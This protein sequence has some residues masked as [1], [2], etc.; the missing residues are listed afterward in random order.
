LTVVSK[1]A[2]AMLRS[3]LNWCT[4]QDDLVRSNELD[5][6]RAFIISHEIRRELDSEWESRQWGWWAVVPRQTAHSHTPRR[7]FARHRA[8]QARR[9][10]RHRPNSQTPCQC[11]SGN[12]ARHRTRPARHRRC[13]GLA[14]NRHRCPSPASPRHR[15]TVG[16]QQQRFEIALPPISVTVTPEEPKVASHRAVLVEA[17]QS[18]IQGRRV[19]PR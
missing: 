15:S 1:R 11:S 13:T 4:R 19:R 5:A 8:S 10:P 3:P 17:H 14:Q 12:R 18:E 9:Q 6:V 2:S 7:R 16:G